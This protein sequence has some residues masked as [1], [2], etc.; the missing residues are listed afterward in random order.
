LLLQSGGLEDSSDPILLL[1]APAA[2]EPFDDEGSIPSNVDLR[3]AVGRS[4]L[5]AT[6]SAGVNPRSAATCGAERKRYG[7]SGTWSANPS[8]RLPKRTSSTGK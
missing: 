2:R 1:A 8:T 4:R 3:N 7:Y 6:Y 5:N